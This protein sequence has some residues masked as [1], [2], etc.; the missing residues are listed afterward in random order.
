MCS[1]YKTWPQIPPILVPR[2][3]CRG[4]CPP[5]PSHQE[6][7]FISL[8]PGHV[9][10]LCNQT[11]RSDGWA[12]YEAAPQEACSSILIFVERCPWTS[13]DR[14]WLPSG[15]HVEGT[16]GAHW[17]KGPC[18]GELG[19]PSTNRK[20]VNGAI[21]DLPSPADPLAECSKGVNSG[22]PAEPPTFAN[23]HHHA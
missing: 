9:I 16:E 15:G 12:G 11:G 18:R 13:V 23:P 4:S 22:R 10:S 7:G 19:C 14:S 3:L 6:W 20:H 8:P 17:G 1:D 2:P 21:P 5:L